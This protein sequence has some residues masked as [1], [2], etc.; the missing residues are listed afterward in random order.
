MGFKKI[1]FCI[2]LIIALSLSVNAFESGDGSPESPYLIYNWTDLNDTR[3][4]LFAYYTLMSNLSSL[5]AD[6]NG[7]GNEW[8]PIG[9]GINSFQ[10]NFNGQNNTISDLIINLPEV[11]YVGLFGFTALSYIYDLGLLNININGSQWTGGLIGYDF[12]GVINNIYG[13]GIVNGGIYTGG[14]VGGNDGGTIENSFSLINVFGIDNVG[15]LAGYGLTVINS[16][17]TGN[18]VGSGNVIGGL[19]GITYGLTDKSYA[20]GNVSGVVTAGGLIGWLEAGLITNSYAT[21]SVTSNEMTGGLLGGGLE[22]IITNCYSKG[23]V[24]GIDDNLEGGLIG[25]REISSPI[26]NSY[27][28]NETSNQSLSDGGIGKTTAEMKCIDNYE[29]WDIDT[30]SA[31]NINDGYPYLS[32]DNFYTWYIYNSVCPLTPEVPP[33]IIGY[34]SLFLPN[35]ITLTFIDLIMI[36][37][38]I[39][40]SFSPIIATVLLYSFIKKV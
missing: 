17:A 5:D 31:E 19:L 12:L 14:L 32:S 27:W 36:I 9:D 30:L 16:Y 34:S 2:L 18:V 38:I 35:D 40:I 37:L 15:G 23:Y 29:S 1:Y 25:Y 26:T 6:Y 7:L 24:Y 21:G 11:N 10:G 4:N 20:T 22:V 33:L 8:I 3:L 28:D 13:T 39:F